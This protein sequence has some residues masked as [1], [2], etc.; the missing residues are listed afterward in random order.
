M[1]EATRPQRYMSLYG[2]RDINGKYRYNEM[3]Q[4]L[5]LMTDEEREEVNKMFNYAD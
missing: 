4:L 3:N 1:T 5:L 2:A